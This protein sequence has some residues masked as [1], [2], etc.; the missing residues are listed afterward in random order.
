MSRIPG[1]GIIGTG[2]VTQGLHLPTLMRLLDRFRV[3]HIAGQTASTT[4]HVAAWHGARAGTD[5]DALLA[6]PAVEVVAINSPSDLHADHA[7]AALEAGKAV[8]VEKPLATSADDA[9][10]ILDCARRTGGH[11]QV[12]TMHVYDPAWQAALARHRD[13]MAAATMIRSTIVLPPNPLFEDWSGQIIG[14]KGY[15]PPFDLS[16]APVRAAIMRATIL[17]LAVHEL[18]LIR[19]IVPDWGD[20]R[21]LS[22]R[23]LPPFAYDI[24]LAVGGRLVQLTA[25]LHTHRWSEWS[26]AFLGADAEVR[27]D[28]TPSYVPAGSGRVTLVSESGTAIVPPVTANG[29]LAQWVQLHDVVCAGAAP[30]H[31][32][33]AAVEDID[34]ALTLADRC[35]AWAMEHA[36]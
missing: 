35:S 5:V 6:D 34:L 28:F 18:P 14:R 3:V 31:G 32:L 4:A 33:A 10:R 22:A 21:V 19:E 2:P 8:L 9:Q 12:G 15:P 26:M 7:I 30:L 25:T 27:V 11:V 13:H 1:V 23:P 16:V 20:L 36:A 17:G 29:Y 24:H